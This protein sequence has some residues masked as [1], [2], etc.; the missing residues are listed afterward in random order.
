MTDSSHMEFIF[1]PTIRGMKVKDEKALFPIGKIYCVGKNY[2]AHAKEMG[3]EV[4]KKEPFF[5]SKPPQALTQLREIPY[6]AK[7]NN[8]HHEVELVVFLHKGGTNIPKEQVEDLIFG[9]AVG[10]DLTKRDLQNQFKEAGKPWDL[11][12]GFDYSGPISEIIRR[13]KLLGDETITLKVNDELRQSSNI[14]LMEWD[15]PSLISILSEQ[16]TLKPGDVI[17]TGTP[18]GV[19]PIVKGDSIFAEIS[20]IGSLD[21]III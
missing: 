3:S 18:E 11:S 17:F 2:A 14:S 16:V 10:V 15:I 9:Y 19:A 12:K 13:E 4:D 6:P 1:P 21:F 5:F 8:L 7:T 20:N